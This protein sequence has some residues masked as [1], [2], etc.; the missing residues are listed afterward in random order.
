MLQGVPSSTSFETLSYSRNP[1]KLSN[2]PPSYND[3]DK[4]KK[5]INNIERMIRERKESNQR[6]MRTMSEEF[7][8]LD[9][10]NKEKG[11]LYSQ[12]KAT[13]RGGLILPLARMMSKSRKESIIIS[14]H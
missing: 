10:S 14:L 6:M 11:I 8:Q 2:S 3:L 4:V 1:D 13:P 7:A 5:K 9:T 12:L